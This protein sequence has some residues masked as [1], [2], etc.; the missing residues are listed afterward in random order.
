MA[1]EMV[2]ARSFAMG[3]VAPNTIGA[4]HT[5]HAHR[6]VRSCRVANG[7]A[8]GLSCPGIRNVP[9]TEGRNV[10]R[11]RSEHLAWGCFFKP[12]WDPLPPLSRCRYLR[13]LSLSLS[14]DSL[15][16]THSTYPSTRTAS[17]QLMRQVV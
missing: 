14:R 16:Y 2:W 11:E 7:V 9:N 6:S 13:Q 17:L 3:H 10:F 15:T 4:A 5:W 1:A 12:D 8:G